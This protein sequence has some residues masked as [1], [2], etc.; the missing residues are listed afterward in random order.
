MQ[1]LGRVVEPRVG[2]EWLEAGLEEAQELG[3]VGHLETGHVLTACEHGGDGVRHVVEMLLAVD[4]NSPDGLL[5]GYM[6]TVGV[7]MLYY[8]IIC[9]IVLYY[10]IF[11]VLYCIVLFYDLASSCLPS[12]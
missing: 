3:L 6:C 9:H 5:P 1:P 4:A 2:S 10:I 11:I 7:R 8:I 12:L